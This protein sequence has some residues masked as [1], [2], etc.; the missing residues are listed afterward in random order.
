MTSRP[1]YDYVAVGHVT[2]DIMADGSRRAG[3]TALYGALQAARLGLR[4]LILTRGLPEEVEQ[5]LRPYSAEL[6]LRVQPAP[7]TTALL[8]S[9]A[10]GQRRQRVLAW[11]GPMR[12]ERLPEAAVV[13]LAPVAAELSGPVRAGSCFLGLT[14]QGLAR[15]WPGPEREIV[16]VAPSPKQQ[17]IAR[18]CDAMVLSVHERG[19]CEGMIEATLRAGGVVAVTAAH[20]PTEIMAGELLERVPVEEVEQPADDLGAG[21]VY[22]SAFFIELAGGA[23][24]LAAARTAAAAAALRML[25][26]GPEAIADGQAI[27]AHV[28]ARIAGG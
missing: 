13:H 28:Q 4:A 8:T 14:P 11:A 6:E 20:E 9:G 26:S 24:P 23:D 7:H 22:A 27:A 15:A 17:A 2:A 5:L 1:R 25:G 3:G 18:E 12:Q 16:T 10:D 21:D 19:A